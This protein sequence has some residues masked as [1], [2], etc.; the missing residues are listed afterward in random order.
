MSEDN[1]EGN[2]ETDLDLEKGWFG[3]AKDSL[4]ENWQTIIIVLIV[5]IIGVGLYNYQQQ[6]GAGTG[7]EGALSTAVEE[8]E[9]AAEKSDEEIAFENDLS[10]KENEDEDG[11]AI[12]IEESKEETGNLKLETENKESVETNGADKD[13][14]TIASENGKAYTA[15]AESGDG[16]THLARKVTGKYLDENDISDIN[17]EQKI[18]IEDYLQNKTGQEFLELGE[19][20]EFSENLIAEA[21]DLS[22]GLNDNDIENL[23]KYKTRIANL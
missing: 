11:S 5:L 3:K 18:F 10:E 19:T 15:S 17:N 2:A 7:E 9:E 14:V 20:R 22:R 23:S 4:I 16:I 12:V 8:R 21:I 6:K 13:S 1:L